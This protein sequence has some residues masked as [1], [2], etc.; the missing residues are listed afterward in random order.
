[1][2]TSLGV[3]NVFKQILLMLFGYSPKKYPRVV[4]LGQ[5]AIIDP[6]KHFSRHRGHFR[7]SV[8]VLMYTLIKLNRFSHPCFPKSV[9]RRGVFEGGCGGGGYLL[10]LSCL[11]LFLFAKSA[12]KSAIYVK[13]GKFLHMITQCVQPK[14]TNSYLPPS[15]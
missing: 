14:V 12:G 2:T 13:N 6:Q 5:G 8:A 4:V 15:R 10:Y 1:M 9:F 3:L 11:P 7:T